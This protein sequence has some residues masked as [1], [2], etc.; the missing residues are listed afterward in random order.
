MAPLHLKQ[1]VE[2]LLL[3]RS[4]C[5]TLLLNIPNELMFLIFEFIIPF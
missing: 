5:D 1:A 4:C 2:T 3:I